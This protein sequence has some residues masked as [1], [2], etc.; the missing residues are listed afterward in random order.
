MKANPG[1]TNEQLQMMLQQFGFPTDMIDTK[2][3]SKS[4]GSDDFTTK[5]E[6]ILAEERKTKQ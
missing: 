3:K 2:S 1:T 5:I 6:K 4:S